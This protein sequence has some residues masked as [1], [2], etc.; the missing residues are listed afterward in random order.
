VKNRIIVAYSTNRDIKAQKFLNKSIKKSIGCEFDIIP[1]SNDGS[2]SLTKAYNKAWENYPFDEHDIFVF[3]HH[4]IH[5]KS[6][7]WGTNLLNL[8]NTSEANIIGVAGTDKL[9]PHGI[10]W[11]DMQGQFNTRDLWGKVWHTDGRKN[12]KSDFTTPLKKCD[13]L[14]PVECIDGV[15]IAFDPDTCEQFDED[16]DSFHFYDL[17]FCARNRAVGN[18]VYVTETIPLIHESEGPIGEIWDHYRQMFVAK[19]LSINKDK[20]L[21]KDI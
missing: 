8:F 7:G 2:V 9:Y 6:N 11:S 18:K 15:F 5:F 17:S 14:Q 20:L 10:W 19:Y 21:T 13:K 3:I 16:F 4:D 12:W 1:I